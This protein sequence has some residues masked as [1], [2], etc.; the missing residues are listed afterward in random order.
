MRCKTCLNLQ[1]EDADPS[2]HSSS[3]LFKTNY[4][5]NVAQVRQSV[6]EGCHFCTLV[7]AGL[8]WNGRGETTLP[9]DTTIRLDMSTERKWD[10]VTGTHVK[11]D[12]A[13]TVR[14]GGRNAT[15]FFK[16][17]PGTEN[18]TLPVVPD[19]ISDTH[20]GSPRSM[21]L[22]K[23]WLHH[24][25]THHTACPSSSPVRLPTRV[26]DVSPSS[27]VDATVLVE[28]AT[29][30]SPMGSYL[31][32]SHCWGTST[33]PLTTTTLTLPTH[34]LSLPPLSSGTLPP[35][36]R[37]AI[38]TTRAL[39]FRYIWID[40]LCILQDSHAD[41]AAES[42]RM[43]AYFSNCTLVLA[44]A[45]AADSIEGMFRARNPWGVQPARIMMRLPSVATVTRVDRERAWSYHA[46]PAAEHTVDVR[47]GMGEW[48]DRRDG[49][50]RIVWGP[51]DGRA[52]T[53]QEL[54][55]GGRVV[56]WE[57]G[58]VRWVCRGG[59]AD[60]NLPGIMD[61]AWQ[62]FAG[63]GLGE[64]SKGLGVGW[65]RLLGREEARREGVE[66]LELYL[67][68]YGTVERYTVRAITKQF[69]ILPAIGG[70]ASRFR[71]LVDDRYVAG[72]WEKDLHHGLLWTVEGPIRPG[73]QRFKA[74]SWSW[75]SLNLT[76]IKFDE[77][78]LPKYEVWERDWFE[79]REITTPAASANEYGEV[80]GGMLRVKGYLREVQLGGPSVA[81]KVYEIRKNRLLNPETG[82]SLGDIFLDH[83]R[84]ST[85][86]PLQVWCLPV[87]HAGSDNDNLTSICL[88]LVPEGGGEQILGRIGL[89]RITN[90]RWDRGFFPEGGKRLV[91]L[92]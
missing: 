45:D 35:T 20:T 39:G 55:L 75:A 71:E 11:Q 16:V 78:P 72:L 22:I 52:W 31:A 69:D 51:L 37:D 38:L 61:P 50:K 88:A 25:Q 59:E 26:I 41:W 82:E 8:S 80:G 86:P 36:F 44:A 3:I 21:A 54:V 49:G 74:P 90:K 77:V 40:S 9:T 15:V 10:K 13:L 5:E 43:G 83:P 81:G 62:G 53:M 92:V 46:W 12:C 91:C 23:S 70:L 87:L 14:I 29:L 18:P 4:H 65:V 17:T 32:L 33:H 6:D 42:S 56:R 28:T 48:V 67:D 1:Y 66:R 57:G 7:L 76:S 60:E 63:Q 84:M 2:S 85:D 24:C 34:L 30:P 68:W 64:V 19:A 73:E 89:A 58:G 47:R 79:V 27:D